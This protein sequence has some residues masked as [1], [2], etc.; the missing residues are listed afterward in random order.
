MQ[1]SLSSPKLLI[2]FRNL[3]WRRPPFWIFGLCEYCGICALYQIG[4]KY[5]HWSLRST[6]LCFRRLFDDVTQID[7]RFRLLVSGHL[8]MAMIMAMMHGHN[9]GHDASSHKIW[10]KFS[11]IFLKFKMAAAAM[12]PPTKEHSWCVLPVLNLV[13]ISVIVT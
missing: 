5:M 2:F 4:L 8:P 9:H 10:C 11:H 3:R 1:I 12:G 6:H 13:Q 7:F